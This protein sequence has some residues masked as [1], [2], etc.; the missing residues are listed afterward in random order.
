MWRVL[1]V[2]WAI[3][4]LRGINT[5][6]IRIDKSIKVNGWSQQPISIDAGSCPNGRCQ[7]LAYAVAANVTYGGAIG[8]DVGRIRLAYDE[9]GSCNDGCKR[10]TDVA[11]DVTTNAAND[12]VA[13]VVAYDAVTHATANDGANDSS[14]ATYDG[15]LE[16]KTYRACIHWYARARTNSSD[17]HATNCRSCRCQACI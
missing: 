9:L 12:A 4:I 8:V 1:S 17:W 6:V 3:L 5:I 15:R 13:H 11:H 14:L 7:R 2:N 10:L 16:R